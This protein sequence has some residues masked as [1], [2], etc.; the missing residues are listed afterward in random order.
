MM[1]YTSEP[2]FG[3]DLISL[4]GSYV[5]NPKGDIIFL[6]VCGFGKM[7]RLKRFGKFID[8]LNMRVSIKSFLNICKILLILALYFHVVTCC[9]VYVVDHTENSYETFERLTGSKTEHVSW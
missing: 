3:F 2:V 5:F 1:F 7:I 9:W 8:S 4:L 6:K